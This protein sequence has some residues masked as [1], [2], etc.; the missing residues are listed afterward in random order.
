M[1]ISKEIDTVETAKPEE[2]F[3]EFS[4]EPDWNSVPSPIFSKVDFVEKKDH[5]LVQIALPDIDLSDIKITASG[6][7]LILRIHREK[8]SNFIRVI[9][10]PTLVNFEQGKADFSNNILTI[11]FPTLSSSREIEIQHS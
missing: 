6:K 9:S 8:E 4:I 7:T 2:E 1:E 5:L 3:A 11:G 10:L